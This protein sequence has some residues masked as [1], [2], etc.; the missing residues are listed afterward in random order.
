MDYIEDKYIPHKTKDSGFLPL[1]NLNINCKGGYEPP[2]PPPPPPPPEMDQ[3][4]ITAAE[5]AKLAEKM[6]AKKRRGRAST[7]LGG[8]ED[9][10][11]PTLGGT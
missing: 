8:K 9:L 6:K 4:A 10:D 5:E 3:A 1:E 2:P 11:D 7:I